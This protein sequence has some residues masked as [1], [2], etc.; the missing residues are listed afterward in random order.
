MFDLSSP[1]SCGGWHTSFDFACLTTSTYVAFPLVASQ[2][3]SCR[4]RSSR[5]ADV[6]AR[7]FKIEIPL[8]AEE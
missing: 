3:S 6:G 8:S 7:H 4:R 1:N 5:W 2:I